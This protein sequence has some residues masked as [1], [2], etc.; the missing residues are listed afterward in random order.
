M[1]VLCLYLCVCMSV[2]NIGP[3]IKTR[4]SY[5]ITFYNA[6]RQQSYDGRRVARRTHTSVD[7]NALT[8]LLRSRMGLLCTLFLQQCSSW[9]DFVWYVILILILIA[10]RA[11]CLQYS[12]YRGNVQTPGP[13]VLWLQSKSIVLRHLSI[14]QVLSRLCLPDLL[15]TFS[16]EKLMVA[17]LFCCCLFCITLLSQ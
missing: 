15:K 11:V 2:A 12:W 7:R 8:A 3:Y 5:P 1:S 17:V 16:V 13:F 10:C 4:S 6:R 9:Q 14:A